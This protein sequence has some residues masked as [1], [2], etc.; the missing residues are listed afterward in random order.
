MEVVEVAEKKSKASPKKA[1]PRAKAEVG[2]KTVAEKGTLVLPVCPADAD[3]LCV[4]PKK[5]SKA[6]LAAQ[7]PMPASTSTTPVPEPKA[8]A[9]KATPKKVA[10][11]KP[12]TYEEKLKQWFVEFQEEEEPGK[13]GGDGIESLFEGMGVSMESVSHSRPRLGPH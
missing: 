11:K 10:P 8:P 3:V 13:M 1:A 5:L 9:K 2:K 6:A 7:T 12:L 4:A